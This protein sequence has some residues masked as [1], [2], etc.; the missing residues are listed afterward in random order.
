MKK[1]NAKQ[2]YNERK[3]EIDKLIANIQK[4]L[5]KHGK[6]EISWAHA[7]DLG[8]VKELLSEIDQFLIIN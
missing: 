1:Q 2:K 3:K 5:D 6:D 8:H 7:G 4:K